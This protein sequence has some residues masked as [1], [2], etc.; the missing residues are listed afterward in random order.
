MKICEVFSLFYSIDRILDDIAVCIDDNG[1][2][3][4]ISTNLIFG[5][6]REGSI[7]KETNDGFYVDIN[8][9]NCRRESNFNLAES[10]FEN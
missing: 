5:D 2:I 8:E 1:E 4:N 6:Y 3:N 9:E 7:L 10:L